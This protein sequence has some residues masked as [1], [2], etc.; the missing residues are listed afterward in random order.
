MVCVMVRVMV[1]VMVCAMVCE[2]H[3][4]DRVAVVCSVQQ[5]VRVK[6]ASW[7]VQKE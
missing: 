7:S 5:S 6:R 3:L 2:M 4:C 1:C